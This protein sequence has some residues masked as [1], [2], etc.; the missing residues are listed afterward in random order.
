MKMKK[1]I[2]DVLLTKVYP[3]EAF[4]THKKDSIGSIPYP[5]KRSTPRQLFTREER[6]IRNGIII[7]MVIIILKA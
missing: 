4:I 6:M 5:P 3:T 1:G 7:R 2:S